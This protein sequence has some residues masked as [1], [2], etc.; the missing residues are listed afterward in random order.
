VTTLAASVRAARRDS[1]VIDAILRS[2]GVARSAAATIFAPHRAG[3]LPDDEGIGD[4]LAGSRT[5]RAARNASD[6]F[7]RAWL[8]SA[9][10]TAVQPVQRSLRVLTGEQ[11]IRA[12][13]LWLAVAATTVGVLSLVDPRPSSFIRWIMWAVSLFVGVTAALAAP[14]LHAAWLGWRRTR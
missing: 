12:A 13:G 1:V 7:E 4:S 14:P 8:D 5:V 6:A 9:A 11:R 10:H 2:I 3:P